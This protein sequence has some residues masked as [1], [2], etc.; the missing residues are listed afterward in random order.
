MSDVIDGWEVEAGK[1]NLYVFP[2]SGRTVRRDCNV[3]DFC[4]ALNAE[5]FPMIDAGVDFE[6]CVECAHEWVGEWGGLIGKLK[7]LA[8]V[9]MTKKPVFF[10]EDLSDLPDNN[11][12]RIVY[13]YWLRNNEYHIS[14]KRQLINDWNAGGR[15]EFPSMMELLDRI[16]AGGRWERS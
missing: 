11:A 8:Y 5:I 13:R 3:G 1:K 4:A 10:V 2:N 9:I 15:I 12:V 16:E 14:K 7:A 6:T